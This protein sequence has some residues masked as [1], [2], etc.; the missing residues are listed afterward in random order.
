MPHSRGKRLRA[1]S[2][3]LCPQK[4]WRR[5]LIRTSGIA[6]GAVLVVKTDV[7]GGMPPGGSD[8]DTGDDGDLQVGARCCWLRPV[9]MQLCSLVLLQEQERRHLA[10]PLV[11]H[12]V[13]QRQFSAVVLHAG[14]RRRGSR[15]RPV[16]RLTGSIKS[17][18]AV[19]MEAAV[20]LLVPALQVPMNNTYTVYACKDPGVQLPCGGEGRRRSSWGA[21]LSLRPPHAA[22]ACSP[23]A[24]QL[25]SSSS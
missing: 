15:V 19:Q 23:P 9:C 16:C 12:A 18:S 22:D 5:P 7:K 11:M 17:A 6:V 2:R 4:W 10:G 8:C 20:T 21:L 3:L 13:V 1:P 14:S 25:Y 24:A